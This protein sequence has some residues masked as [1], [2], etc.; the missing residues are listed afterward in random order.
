MSYRNA[1]VACLALVAGICSA[2]TPNATDVWLAKT[3]GIWELKG[4]YGYYQVMVYREGIEHAVDKVVVNLIAA[5]DKAQRK[6]VVKSVTLETPGVQGNVQDIQFKMVDKSH[7]VI[8]L[9]V[10]MKGME[11][12]VERAMFLFYPD[13]RYKEIISLKHVDVYD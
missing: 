9:D 3:S 13:G 11:G 8:S 4:R 6:E 7:M 2:A 1:L 12:V 5:D 10:T